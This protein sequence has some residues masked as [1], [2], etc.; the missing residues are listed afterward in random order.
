[1][2]D[3]PVVDNFGTD[4]LFGGGHTMAYILS[5][6]SRTRKRTGLSHKQDAEMYRSTKYRR[7]KDH[8]PSQGRIKDLS[9]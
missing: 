7:I 3:V 2:I 4:S 6:R 8:M 1:M 5:Y 9:P